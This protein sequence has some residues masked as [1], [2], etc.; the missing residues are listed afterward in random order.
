VTTTDLLFTLNIAFLMFFAWLVIIP[1][2]IFIA[3]FAK[4]FLKTTWFKLHVGIQV[5]LS[6]PIVLA[7]SSLSFAAAGNL[8]FD[9]PHK[10]N[11]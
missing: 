7:G 4:N 5:F 3:R 9:D 6:I 1:S 11:S 2:A 8:I 10:V